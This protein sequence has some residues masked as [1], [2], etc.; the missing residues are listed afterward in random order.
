MLKLAEVVYSAKE[1]YSDV[2]PS[3][4]SHCA[5]CA[6]IRICCDFFFGEDFRRGGS[7]SRSHSV[8]RSLEPSRHE[9][10]GGRF[11][12]RRRFDQ[13][14]GNALAGESQHRQGTGSLPSPDVQE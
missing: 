10:D 13:R 12:R 14:G 1:F 3:S 2:D 9:S 8:S 11:Y 4:S 5:C 6:V 7:S